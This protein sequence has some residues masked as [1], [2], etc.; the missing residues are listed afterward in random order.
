MDEK[1]GRRRFMGRGVK[2]TAALGLTKV[3]GPSGT[4][5]VVDWAARIDMLIRRGFAFHAWKPGPEYLN[6]LPRFLAKIQKYCTLEVFTKL[7]GLSYMGM[8][9]EMWIDL[10]DEYII[11]LAKEVGVYL[12]YLQ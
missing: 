10:G 8:E 12:R 3:I 9:Y 4:T 7:K 6:D 5:K 1:M 2:A 11:D